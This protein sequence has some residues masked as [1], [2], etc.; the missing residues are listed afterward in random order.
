VG[1]WAGFGEEEFAVNF[2]TQAAKKLGIAQNLTKYQYALAKAKEL[3]DKVG[4]NL[5]DIQ[6]ET[7]IESAYKGTKNVLPLQAVTNVTTPYTQ[8]ELVD[9][10]KAEVQRVAPNVLTDK[11]DIVKQ[12]L[13]KKESA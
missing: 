11:I 8:D 7:L 6:W 9:M 3:A 12:E 10:I 2:A 4:I 5:T 1:S 13:G